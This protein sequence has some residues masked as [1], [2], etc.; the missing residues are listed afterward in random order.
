MNSNDRL[1]FCKALA[2]FDEATGDL[3]VQQNCR[4]NH[5]RS[6]WG[7]K[8]WNHHF[9][10]YFGVS[11]RGACDWCFVCNCSS[12]RCWN[13]GIPATRNKAWLMQPWL[14]SIER[15]LNKKLDWMSLQLSR[16]CYCQ[17][18]LQRWMICDS[19]FKC[20]FHV[21]CTRDGRACFHST[22]TVTDTFLTI[23]WRPYANAASRCRLRNE[24]KT[25]YAGS[26]M[27]CCLVT[28]CY[29]M[30]PTRACDV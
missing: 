5:W 14:G 15:C 20:L 10:Q 26:G 7:L 23:A 25:R 6:F 4:G 28:Q 1:P 21:F 12:N 24:R 19:I 30:L 22:N 18:H 17:H 2:R 27:S 13:N 9:F 8:A 11:A 16:R 3:V 29:P